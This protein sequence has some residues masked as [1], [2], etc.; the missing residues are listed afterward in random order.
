M[1]TRVSNFS[2]LNRK[3]SA[4][5]NSYKR[6]SSGIEQLKASVR[7]ENAMYDYILKDK[8]NFG[9]NM[10]YLFMKC[11]HEMLHIEIAKGYNV[12]WVSKFA[13][14]DKQKRLVKKISD[15]YSSDYKKTGKLRKQLISDGR[16]SMDTV[17]PK[18]TSKLKKFFKYKF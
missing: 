3:I 12:D 13:D 2:V 10:I 11:P 4:I 6:N 1:I 18:M 14:Y 16:I 9:A 17:V 5:E 7:R 15:L 8:K